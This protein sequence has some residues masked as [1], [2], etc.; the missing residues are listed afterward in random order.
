MRSISE[1]IYCRECKKNTNHIILERNGEELKFTVSDADFQDVDFRFS[2]TYSI[3]RCL[4]CD[5]ISFCEEYEDEDQWEPDYYTGEQRWY[6]K[7]TVYPEAPIENDGYHIAK[8]IRLIPL[9]IKTL[10]DEVVNSF[11][12]NSLILCAVGLRM[13][14]EGIC[15]D[16]NID[17][18]FL[19]NSDGSPK[20]DS[21]GKQKIKFRNLEEKINELVKIGLITVTQ[22]NI[23][24][25][26]RLMGNETVHE[27]RSHEKEVLK[28]SLE[29]L[30]NL[31]FNIYELTKIELFKK[32]DN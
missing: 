16:K 17:K 1:K 21:D 13:I 2:E 24:H 14:I 27:I 19:T 20:I 25:Q 28:S 22:A 5:N 4:G 23:L 15:K 12:S 11:N 6:S 9:F 31:L 26:I 18:V 3:V 7:F 10:H 32:E 8:K 30:E 29:I